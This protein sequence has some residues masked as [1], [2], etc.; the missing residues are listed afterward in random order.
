MTFDQFTV[1]L[2]TRI[3]E[4]LFFVL[5]PVNG[6]TRALALVSLYGHPH[7]ALYTLSSK[8]YW[9]SQHL[10]DT[11]LEIID[12]QCINSVVMMAPDPQYPFTDGTE[13]DRWF[14]M[15]KPGLKLSQY[16]GANADD[17]E[18]DN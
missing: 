7:E 13:T 16:L 17:K 11:S 10:R 9:T 1:N 15:E 4:V 14:L 18:V 5:M 6:I 2:Q 8:T 12:V 3:A